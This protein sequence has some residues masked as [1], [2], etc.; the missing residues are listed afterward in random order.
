MA[1]EMTA[2]AFLAA[3]R[4]GSVI[5]RAGY[6]LTMVML[7][8]L[9]QVIVASCIVATGVGFAYGALPALIME[10]VPVSETAAANGLNA[11]MRSIGTTV[12]SAVAGL[13]LAHMTTDFHGVHIPTENGLRAVLALGVGAGVLSFTFA[14]LIPRRP[15]T[16]VPAPA[17]SAAVKTAGAE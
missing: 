10:A 13:I 12:S 7:S 5:V 15:P 4:I 1:S 2:P 6:L 17:E 16:E 14:S 3:A 8:G 9:W 11:L